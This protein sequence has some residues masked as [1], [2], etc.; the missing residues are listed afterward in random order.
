MPEHPPAPL[1][2]MLERLGLA[3]ADQIAKM[4]R[5]VNRLARDLP[6]FESVWV[7]ALCQARILSPFQAAEI[8][9]GRGESLRAGPYLIVE[10][11]PH[12]YYVDCYRAQN[13]ETKETVRLAIVENSGKPM[14]GIVRQLEAAGKNRIGESPE[15]LPSL[16]GIHPH[17]SPQRAMNEDWLD[18]GTKTTTTLQTP[19][20]ASAENGRIVVAWPWV[21]G[22]TAAEWMVHHGRFSPEIVLEIARTMAASL[23]ELES[24]EVC[25]SDVS[26]SSLVLTDAGEAVLIMPGLRTILRPEEG[27]A[28]AD[29][30]PEAYDTLAPE[31]VSAGTHPNMQSDMYACGC[32]WWQLL[33]G[34]PPLAGGDSLAKLRSAQT[35]AICDVRRYAPDVPPSLAAAISAC[36]QHEPSRRPDSM[37]RLAAMLG[38]STRSGKELLADHLARTGRATVHWATTVRSMRRSHRTPLWIAGAVCCLATAIAIAWPS[39]RERAAGEKQEAEV[40]LQTEEVRAKKSTPTKTTALVARKQDVPL[41]QNDIPENPVIPTAYQQVEESKPKDFVLPSEKKTDAAAIRPQARQR[42]RAEAGHRASILVSNAGLVVDKEDVCFENVDFVWR[43]SPNHADT[44]ESAIVQ[45]LASRAVFRGCSFQCE[46]QEAMASAVRWTYPAPTANA[47][48]ALPSGR[49]QMTDCVLHRVA[50]GVECH[51]IGALAIELKNVLHLTAGPLVRLDHCPQSDEPLSILLG[52]V[53]LRDA[54]PLLECQMPRIESQPAEIDIVA[55]ACAFAPHGNAPL[56]RLTGRELC[57]RLS[58][59]IH[60]SGQ[61][62]LVTPR[63]PIIAWRGQD[64]QD[65]PLDESTLSIAGL[66]RSEVGFAGDA[67]NDPATSQLVRWQAPLQSADPPGIDP[68]VLPNMGS[69]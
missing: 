7:D 64:N 45:L 59:A 33:C 21:D 63:S 17:R 15:R 55:T 5:R 57:E 8:N 48:L 25:H 50:V 32:V 19:L 27:Y 23:A 68:G 1:V 29:L 40:R 31:R 38:P 46:S 14:D 18:K 47:E 51:A 10:R 24:V 13:V 69:K 26:V 6:R 58:A 2:E 36:L 52:Q 67:A 22:R 12:P 66:V 56:V 37:A 61:G 43:E 49:L 65:Q 60:W 53:T 41:Q 3:T 16:P 44:A 54:G 28:H 39:P 20:S 9:A 42:V 35:G 4:G 62:S 34:R 30:M 11:L